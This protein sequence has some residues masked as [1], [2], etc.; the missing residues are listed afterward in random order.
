MVA[1]VTTGQ[2]PEY[3]VS[4]MATITTW[5]KEVLAELG[6]GEWAGL[7]RVTSV[8]LGEVYDAGIFENAM[9]YRLDTSQ[10]V[11]LLAP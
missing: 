3:R 2:R 6:M 9:W 4:R 11:P 7:F 10:P 1:Y 5:T 8:V